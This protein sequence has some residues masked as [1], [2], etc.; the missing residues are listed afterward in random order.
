MRDAISLLDQLASTGQEITVETAHNVLGTAASQ[1][2]LALVEALLSGESGPGIDQI[3]AS[4]DAGSDPRQYARQIVDYLREL[5]LIRMGNASQVDAPA[6]VR[7]QM[8][9]HAQSFETSELLKVIR[10]FNHAAN[11]ARLSWQPALPLEMALIESIAQTPTTGSAG[12][13][14]PPPQND[15]SEKESPATASGSQPDVQT[16]APAQTASVSVT[17]TTA[18]PRPETPPAPAADQQVNSNLDEKWSRLLNLVRSRNPNTY[19]LLNSCKSRY[20]RREN[21]ILNFASDV[22]KN[23]MEKAENIEVVQAAVQELFEGKLTVRCYVDTA[24]RDNLPPGVENDGMV[25]TALRD[26]GGEIVDI[27]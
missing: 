23:K 27:Q 12:A 18:A 10:A 19:G 11:E 9:R 15:K 8:A 4:L 26:L 22:L 25:A 24:R 3:H 5:L 6:E 20:L 21:L 7:A 17:P 1:S 14:G 13:E 2:V 16:K